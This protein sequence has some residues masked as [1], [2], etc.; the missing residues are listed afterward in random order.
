MAMDQKQRTALQRQKACEAVGI[1]HGITQLFGAEES[2]AGSTFADFEVWDR[3]VRELER[4]IF[5]EGPIA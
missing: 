4:W 2:P 5:E 3:K 1:L